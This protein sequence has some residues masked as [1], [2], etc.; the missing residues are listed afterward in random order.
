M[1]MSRDM[2]VLYA[3]YRRLDPDGR[4]VGLEAGPETG[5]WFC[6]P[7]GTRVLG[8][9]NGAHYGT[10]EGFGDLVFCVDPEPNGPRYVSP[11]ARDLR[12]LLRL[13]LAVGNAN[14]LR[15]LPGWDRAD[16]DTFRA[17]PEMDPFRDRSQAVLDRLRS[18]LDLEP[19]PDPFGYVK[20]LQAGFPYERLRFS[21][22]Y[23]DVLGLARPHG[24]E[25]EPGRWAPADVG[26]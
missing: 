19:M 10:I 21:D 6:T 2:E 12:D 3:A 16:Y 25:P 1:S 8:W 26:P 18:G 13:L 11:L 17:D 23:Y 20:A 22:E 4:W 24:D 5:D 15:Q 7:V 14:V 9:D